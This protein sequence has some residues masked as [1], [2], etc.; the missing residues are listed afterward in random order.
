MGHSSSVG[1]DGGDLK[2]LKKRLRYKRLNPCVYL[3][4]SF[5][6]CSTVRVLSQVVWEPH[7]L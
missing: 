3:G 2:V 5:L 1:Q 7:H 6:I 4:L